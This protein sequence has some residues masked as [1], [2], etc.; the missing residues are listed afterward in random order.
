MVLFIFILVGNEFENPEECGDWLIH[1][2]TTPTE[3]KIPI[4]EFEF[5]EPTLCRYVF[6]GKGGSNLVFH[7][8]SMNVSFSS[9]RFSSVSCKL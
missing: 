1:V 2:G 5:K 8:T 6:V 7:I 9:G 3:F 4:D